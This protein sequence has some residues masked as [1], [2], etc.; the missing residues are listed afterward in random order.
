VLLTPVPYE[1]L[2]HLYVWALAKDKAVASELLEEY[3][4]KIKEW[5]K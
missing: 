1:A 5:Q 3:L 2:V 4:S